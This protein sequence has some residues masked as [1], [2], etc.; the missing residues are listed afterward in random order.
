MTKVQES[1]DSLQKQ[2]LLAAGH[3]WSR[4]SLEQAETTQ[5]FV[6][7]GTAHLEHIH[8]SMDSLFNQELIED[9]PTGIGWFFR[10]EMVNVSV[11]SVRLKFLFLL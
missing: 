11:T 6:Q 8:S 4:Q 7:T 10:T 3:Q 2:H 5:E 9:K 1:V